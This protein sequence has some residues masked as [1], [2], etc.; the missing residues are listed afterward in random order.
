MTVRVIWDISPE[1]FL[2]NFEI[3]PSLSEGD[4][5]TDENNEGDISQITQ[6]GR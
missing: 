6:T 4:F 2:I 1:L 5:S 3:S